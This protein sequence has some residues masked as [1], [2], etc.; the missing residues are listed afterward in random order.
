MSVPPNFKELANVVNDYLTKGSDVQGVQL[1]ARE[2]GNPDALNVFPFV[3][4]GLVGAHLVYDCTRLNT[5]V[6]SR[7]SPDFQS[8]RDYLPTV[9]YK[10]KLN[11]TR[12]TVEVDAAVGT[13]KVSAV[14]PVVN[15]SCK[16]ALMDGGVT[17]VNATTDLGNQFFAGASLMY[18][19][20]RSGLR[21]ATAVLVRYGCPN[22]F[23]GDLMA[24][25]DLRYGFSLHMRVPLHQYM[26]A[27]VAAE[28]QR[29]IAGIQGRSPC[30]ARLMLNANVTDGT[31][32]ATAI[33]NFG[34]IWKFTLTMTAPFSRSGNA[35]APRYGL[36][37]THMDA[38][39]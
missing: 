9:T 34:D 6:R 17:D 16:T 20:K 33:R 1:D 4:K 37:F 23:R 10:T 14:H 15:A 25:Y 30:G 18:D 35:V 21:N 11:G 8:W 29:F 24:K 31:Y 7:V 27:A 36:K 39:D 2:D 13:V 32:T 28:R 26:D 22:I 19:P 38:T 12:N 3:R 5:T